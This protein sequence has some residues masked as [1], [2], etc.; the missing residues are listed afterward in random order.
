MD[1]ATTA[2]RV[3]HGPP[4]ATLAPFPVV[5]IGASA[6]GLK[7]LQQFVEA[8][9]ADGGMA[10]VVIMHLDPDRES[11]IAE[12]LQDRAVIGVTQ[13]S[14]PT[15]VEAD[16][17]YVIPPDRDLAMEGSSI[18][19]R[20]RSERFERAPV[21]LFFRT[22]SEACGLDAIGVVL[23]GTGAD[24]TLGIQAI[25]QAGGI[26]AAQSPSE[27]EY[28]GMPSSA[29]ATGRVDVV[30]PASRI[31]DELLRLRR[32]PSAEAKR[33]TVNGPDT[34]ALL[35]EVFAALREATGHDFRMYKRSTVLRRLDRRLLFTGVGGLEDYVQL[36]RTSAAECA[37]LLGDL[38]I[39]VSAFFR[40]PET[41]EALAG[42]VPALFEGKRSGDTVR[43]W[44][45]GCATGEEVYSIAMV[46]AEHAATLSVPPGIQM[47]ATDI[48]E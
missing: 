7:A 29:I 28:A 15:N 17:I 39:S 16:H 20:A 5:G 27:A 31:P 30:L 24:G 35:D 21:D 23:S 10:Y 1:Y 25:R 8:I 37:F 42:V 9:P 38:L 40:D 6:G 3:P 32:E 14:G 48:D 47:F 43:V 4:Q 36:L 33:P 34:D 45:V 41:F 13:V 44:V 19:T 18:V 26:T 11:R 2:D 22:L 12:L 46:L